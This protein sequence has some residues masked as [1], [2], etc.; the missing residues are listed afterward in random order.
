M[1]DN[2]TLDYLISQLPNAVEMVGGPSCGIEVI[3]QPHERT[4]SIAHDHGNATYERETL[5]TA[6]YLHPKPTDSQ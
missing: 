4:F 2:P 5:E 3:A 1:S 6:V